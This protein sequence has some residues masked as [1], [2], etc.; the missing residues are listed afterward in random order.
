VAEGPVRVI[1]D[2]AEF[3][4][5][6]A[7]EVLVAPYTNPS[8]TPLFQR[9]IA[10]VVDSGAAGSH[11][12]I[13]ACEYGIPAVMGTVDGTR[14]LIEGERVHVDGT[15]DLV[16]RVAERLTGYDVKVQLG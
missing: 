14:R 5:L 7:G 11:A 13:A 10:V 2:S 8:W 1:R 15:Q 6:H 4:K 3:G 16:F 9:A 12:A